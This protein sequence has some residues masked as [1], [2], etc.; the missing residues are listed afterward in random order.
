MAG[1]V[2][3]GGRVDQLEEFTRFGEAIR[4][5]GLGRENRFVVGQPVAESHDPFDPVVDLRPGDALP[6]DPV[7]HRVPNGRRS[8]GDRQ[9][10]PE[11]KVS[12]GDDL[13]VVGVELGPRFAS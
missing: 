3:V 7:E 10:Q 9:I 2:G 12:A 8:L 13:R 4:E 11:P 5:A 6:N 1:T